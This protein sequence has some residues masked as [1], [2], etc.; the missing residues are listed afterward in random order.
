MESPTAELVPYHQTL[1]GLIADATEE[2][3]RQLLNPAPEA[4]GLA[5][6]MAGAGVSAARARI[7]Q[8]AASGRL[9]PFTRSPYRGS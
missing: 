4:R 3:E 2:A 1:G 7:A 8:S 5:R 6:L 9:T